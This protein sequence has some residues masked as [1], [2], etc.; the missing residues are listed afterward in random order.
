M[1]NR[2]ERQCKN[3][4]LLSLRPENPLV[5]APMAGVTDRPFRT[6]VKRQ[7]AGIVCMEMISANAIKYGNANC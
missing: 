6:L 4:P 2:E 7:G 1:N 3:A 5:L